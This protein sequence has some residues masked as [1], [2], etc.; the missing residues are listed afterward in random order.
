[1]LFLLHKHTPS[2]TFIDYHLTS[3]FGFTKMKTYKQIKDLIY[4][5]P[6]ADKQNV[7]TDSKEEEKLKSKMLYDDLLKRMNNAYKRN[8]R[9]K[10]IDK[11]K[12]NS[13]HWK[14]LE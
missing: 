13:S 6:R 5:N 8:K 2:S 3:F 9:E 11:L 12:N 4:N 1:M 10:K 14:G 7:D